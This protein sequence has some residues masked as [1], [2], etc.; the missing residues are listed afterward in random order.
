MK[1]LLYL[2][3]FCCLASAA[4]A[5]HGSRAQGTRKAARAP[6][7][8][9]LEPRRIVVGNDTLFAY[10]R[11]QQKEIAKLITLGEFDKD[12]LAKRETQLQKESQTVELQRSMLVLREKEI[13]EL[14]IKIQM[15]DNLVSQYE[16]LNQLQK[17]Q[18]KQKERQLARQSF[19]NKLLGV[20]GG[21]VVILLL[22]IL[23]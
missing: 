11:T 4:V 20:L 22:I 13:K 3:F 23:L 15:R 8:G 1:R 6:V 18:L 17:D 12:E 2:V 21:L 16:G 14:R 10:S 19:K 9:T 7:P 5:Q